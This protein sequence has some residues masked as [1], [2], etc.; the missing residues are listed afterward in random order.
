MMEQQD[1]TPPPT[2]TRHLPDRGRLLSNGL[3]GDGD[4]GTARDTGL[5]G[6][7]GLGEWRGGRCNWWLLLGLRDSGWKR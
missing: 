6:R 5:T 4:D 2:A 7:R 3:F 1:R